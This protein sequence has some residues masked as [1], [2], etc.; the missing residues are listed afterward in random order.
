[1]WRD[2]VLDQLP[3]SGGSSG[4][5]LAR[6]FPKVDAGAHELRDRDLVRFDIL[7]LINGGDQLGELG[8]GLPLGAA[9]G[10]ELCAA[11]ARF[12]VPTGVKFEPKSILA[13]L[14]DVALVRERVRL[15]RLL[16]AML[17]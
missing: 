1:V 13:A 7:A 6:R 3:I 15:L 10:D 5:D 8:L 11:L 17:T 12:F 16:Q 4:A 9:E 14:L 2:L